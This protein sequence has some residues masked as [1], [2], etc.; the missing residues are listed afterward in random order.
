M[1]L[2]NHDDGTWSLLKVTELEHLMLNRIP[3]AA[4]PS[5]CEEAQHRL[6]PSPIAPTANV[7]EHD[8]ADAVS[9]WKEYIEPDLRSEFRDSLKIVA[10][11]LGG[12]AERSIDGAT[13]Y[14]IN[15]PKAHADHWCSALNQARLVIHHRHALPNEDVEMDSDPDAEKWMAMLQSEIYSIVMEF[16]VTCVLWPK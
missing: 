1:E 16:L 15:V 8:E 11:D 13:F 3:D 5:D 12:A 4:D 2:I 10:D 7:D 6:Y 14:Q 9:D